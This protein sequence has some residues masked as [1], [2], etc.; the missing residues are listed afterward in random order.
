MSVIMQNKFLLSI[1][2][3]YSIKRIISKT[4]DKLNSKPIIKKIVYTFLRYSIRAGTLDSFLHTPSTEHPIHSG[5]QVATGF[6]EIC[7]SDD[8]DTSSVE[9]KNFHVTLWCWSL[10]KETLMEQ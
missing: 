1:N 9:C 8:L 5:F 3:L 10:C 6:Q 7:V 4:Q 2:Q